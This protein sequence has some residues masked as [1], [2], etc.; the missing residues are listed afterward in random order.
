M[1]SQRTQHRTF[2]ALLELHDGASAVTA[3]GLGQVDAAAQIVDLKQGA[4]SGTAGDGME[5]HG[6]FVVDVS[7]I[8]QTTGDELYTMILEGSNA[9]D[10]ASGIVQLAV[11]Q[12][13]DEDT[14]LGNCDIDMETGRYVVPFTNEKNDVFY[15]YVRVA[16]VIGGTSPSITCH[17]RM[18][19]M[20]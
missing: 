11:L 4:S 19:Q 16:F 9:S 5:T 2:D 1:A 17:A 15:R 13:G 8:D 3:T 6:E 7:A 18:Q 10:F 14:M 20:A 12:L